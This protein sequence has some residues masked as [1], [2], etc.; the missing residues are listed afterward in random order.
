LV[1]IATS[2]G[3]LQNLCQVYNRHTYVYNAENLVEIGQVAAEVRHADI[4]RLVQKGAASTLVISGVTGPIFIKFAQ[5][6]A[7]IF[8]LNIFE[9]E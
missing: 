4:C 1:A 2:L 8:P 7:K 5:D 6:V 9:S 3:L